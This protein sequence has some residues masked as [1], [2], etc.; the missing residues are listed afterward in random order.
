MSWFGQW[1]VEERNRFINRLIQQLESYDKRFEAEYKTEIH[2]QNYNGLVESSRKQLAEY[3]F[4][5]EMKKSMD[6]QKWSWILRLLQ[7]PA[8]FYQANLVL[9]Y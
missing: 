5:K 1:E 8:S 3:L 4:Y 6:Q 2:L 7:T 9:V